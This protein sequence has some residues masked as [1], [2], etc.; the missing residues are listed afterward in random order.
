MGCNTLD[1]DQS[2]EDSGLTKRNI[3]ATSLVFAD[4]SRAILGASSNVRLQDCAMEPI[5]QV[6]SQI[7][8]FN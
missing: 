1:I 7:E 5:V 6:T 2:L 4:V 3:P 8:T